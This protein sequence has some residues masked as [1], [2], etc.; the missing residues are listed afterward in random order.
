MSVLTSLK[1]VAAKRPMKLSPVVQRRNRVLH[2]LHEQI[3]LATA[4]AEGKQYAPTKFKT[5][6]DE[7]TGETKTIQMP[8]RI[9]EW[10]FVADTGK[11]CVSL[12]YGAKVLALSSKGATA[13]E[14]SA[15]GS[16]LV[17]TL[18][19][20]KTAVANGELDTQIEV[21]AGAV[22]TKLKK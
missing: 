7:A 16:D 19:A 3:L 12:K 5:V 9:K 13:V 21:V 8:K 17:L 6:K 18:N 15:D 10:W 14:L 2:R 22:R 20:L 4:A 11:L 1:L